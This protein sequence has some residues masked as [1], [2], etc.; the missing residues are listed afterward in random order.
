MTSSSQTSNAPIS[1]FAF[2]DESGDRGTRKKSSQ[3]LAF[4]AYVVRKTDEPQVRAALAQ[5]RSEFGMQAGAHLHFKSLS[6]H[7]KVR[8]IEVLSA[9]P[10]TCFIVALCK[11]GGLPKGTITADQFYNWGVRLLLERLSWYMR[12]TVGGTSNLSVTVAHTKGYT[13]SKMHTYVRTLKTIP[14]QVA[15]Q[16]LNTPI[17]FNSTQVDERLQAAD[18]IASAA[19]YALEPI[20]TVVEPR[21]LLACRTLLWRRSGALTSYGFKMHPTGGCP[22]A[23]PWVTSL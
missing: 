14:T 3:H 11:R 9:T 8:A 23:H 7:K 4:G 1:H 10:I 21:Y 18:A 15:W 6:H 22:T 20:H 19:G 17:R 16:H 12:D 13:V 5:I 2:V